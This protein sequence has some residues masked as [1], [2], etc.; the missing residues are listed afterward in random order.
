MINDKLVYFLIQNYDDILRAPLS[1]QLK[2]VYSLYVSGGYNDCV[3]DLS[4][5]KSDLLQFEQFWNDIEDIVFA[6]PE[7][8]QFDQNLLVAERPEKIV[9]LDVFSL[10]ILYNKLAS[11]VPLCI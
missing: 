6:T 1:G 8:I 9:Y 10:K 5:G 2:D 11:S 4:D 7:S 3:E